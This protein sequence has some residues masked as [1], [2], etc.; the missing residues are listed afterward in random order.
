MKYV[1]MLGLLAVAAAAM[2]AFAAGASADTATSPAGTTYTST[3]KATS[4]H[5]SLH[6]GEGSSFLTVTCEHSEVEGT[7]TGHGKGVAVSGPISKL[8]FTKCGND[9][10]TVLKAGSLSAE[11]IGGGPNGTLKSTGAEVR[12]HTSE[13]P[14]C[15]VTTNGSDI[16]TLTGGASAKLD[17]GSAN[18][19]MTGFLCPSIGV[20]TG[21]YTVTSPANLTI[22]NS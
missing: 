11:D 5:T 7:I 12:I 3:I 9:T 19:T 4:T 14:V 20:W 15:T 6:P 10:V 21:S 13:G 18:L 2:M 17:I 8:T 22:D 1:K 16:G